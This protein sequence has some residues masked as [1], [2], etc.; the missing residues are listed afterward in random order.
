MTSSVG[1]IELPV[2]ADDVATPFVD[3]M[4]VGLLDF[5][6]FV[7]K[8]SI[9]TRLVQIRTTITD[10]CPSANRFDYDPRQSFARD[11]TKLP[12]L[13]IW[14]G[15]R[16]KNVE[17][18]TVRNRRERELNLLYVIAPVRYPEGATVFAGALG[19]ADAAI[20]EAS[21]RGYHP[22]YGFRGDPAG[23]LLARSLAPV[24]TIGWEYTGGQVG[25]LEP[26]PRKRRNN[27]P[28]MQEDVFPALQGTIRVM[29]RRTDNADQDEDLEDGR[30]TVTSDGVP[31]FTRVLT[32]PS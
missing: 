4:I 11:L 14:W 26:V 21:D 6:G 24:G 5:L 31:Y 7:V 3:P 15:G 17:A 2:P 30:L 10:A 9:E 25:I 16:S 23:T 27:D 22:A 1:A 29:E 13:Y 20:C 12:A 19:A 32:A 18:T 28:N 8:A